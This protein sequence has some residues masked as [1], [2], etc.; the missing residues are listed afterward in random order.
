VFRPREDS[1]SYG[2]GIDIGTTFVAAAL[3]RASTTEMVSLGNRSAV[4][5]ARVYVRHDG[6]IGS[7]DAVGLPAVGGEDRVCRAP[8]SRMGDPTPVLLGDQYYEP[9]AVLGVLLHDVV[10]KVTQSQD[11]PPDHIVMT[12]PAGWGPFRCALLEEAARQAGLD[13]PGLV[14]ESE[15]AVAHY[16]ASRT[17]NEGETVAVYDL[18]ASSFT[19][20]VLRKQFGRMQ[21]L[22]EP[23]TLPVLLPTHSLQARLAQNSQDGLR[24]QVE[25]T[26]KALSQALRAAQVEPAKLSA[27]LLVGGSPHLPLV[28]RTMSDELG[29]PAVVDS[30]PQHVVALGAARLAAQTAPRHRPA[31]HGRPASPA[32]TAARQ[33]ETA[34]PP[35]P[36]QRTPPREVAPQAGTVTL[37][38]ETASETVVTV[39]AMAPVATPPAPPPPIPVTSPTPHRPRERAAGGGSPPRSSLRP[40]RV[41]LG[42]GAVVALTGLIALAVIGGRSV[43]P[44]AAPPLTA[45]PPAKAEPTAVAE[46]GPQ[47]AVPGAKTTVQ[48]TRSPAFVAVSP[49]GSYAYT[50]NPETQTLTVVDTAANEVVETIPIAAGPPQFL[51]F[52]PDGHTLYIS[53]FNDAQTIH[54][55]G[56]LDTDSN[57]MIATIPQPGRPYIPE[58]TP[59]ET[60]LYVPNHDVAA[61]S[62]IDTA[63]NRVVGEIGVPANPHGVDFSPDGSRAYTANHESNMVSVIDTDTLSVLRTIRVGTSPHSIAVNPRRPLAAETNFD[64]NSVS[65]IDTRTHQV[66]ATIP[67]GENPQ[68][69]AWAPD[70]QHAFVVNHGSNTVSVIDATTNRVTTTLRTG[71]GPTSIALAPDGHRAY[72]SNQDSATLTVLD[73]PG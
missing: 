50:A 42:T 63:T 2:L 7:G 26:I 67:V 16:T 8:L 45:P 44:T 37:G 33:Q 31:Q 65:A 29:Y 27:V 51:T 66:V 1:V 3:A 35:I 4:A 59:D 49:N 36:A 20:T 9:T 22:G 48:L 41:L 5:P 71:T 21:I 60:R 13:R 15:A 64:S 69:I 30:D 6:T 55:I 72:V 47:V 38:T 61:V 40:P 46:V 10:Q 14:S 70:G 11:E 19:V 34:P 32:P 54:A 58:L 53:L 68:D 52:A 18:G 39:P 56:V 23:A 43:A 28:A 12:H 62:V 25:S 24:A 17:L 57:T 73:L